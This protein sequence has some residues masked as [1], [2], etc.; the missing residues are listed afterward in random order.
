ML[1]R[2]LIVS[3]RMWG[4]KGIFQFDHTPIQGYKE[5]FSICTLKPV[6]ITGGLCNGNIRLLI[7]TFTFKFACYRTDINS[8]TVN[9]RVHSTRLNKNKPHTWTCQYLGNT[10]SVFLR[11]KVR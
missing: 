7:E 10:I 6:F 1:F 4:D 2:S 9:L 3:A 5:P 8:E 11:V